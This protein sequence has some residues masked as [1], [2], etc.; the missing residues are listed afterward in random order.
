MNKRIPKLANRVGEE[1]CHIADC[2]NELVEAIGTEGM[3]EISDAHDRFPSPK[4]MAATW[5]RL[6]TLMQA[7]EEHINA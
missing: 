2:V 7:V 4:A 1:I 6:G 3:D 5:E